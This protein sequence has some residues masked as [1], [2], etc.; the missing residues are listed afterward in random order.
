MLFSQP[1]TCLINL[2]WSLRWHSPTRSLR[3]TMTQSSFTVEVAHQWVPGRS[4]PLLTPHWQ[5]SAE[6]L[7]AATDRLIEVTSFDGF[8]RLEE[9]LGCVDGGEEY[10]N[11]PRREGDQLEWIKTR[12][13]L[14]EA[15]HWIGRR[16]MHLGIP[17]CQTTKTGMGPYG[18]QVPT[19]PQHK[20]KLESL[21][22]TVVL[23]DFCSVLLFSASWLK[24][25]GDRP[26]G[27][28][29]ERAEFQSQFYYGQTVRS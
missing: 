9:L 26:W 18:S 11:S 1:L 25:C 17:A 6:H 22:T 12:N 4:C 24:T 2:D 14:W 10:Y 15:F 5:W 16:S 29:P 13:T 21:R 28:A 19:R 7:L 27:L 20:G 8:L 23:C 3:K